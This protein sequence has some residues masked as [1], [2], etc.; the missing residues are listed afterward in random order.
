MA[1]FSF[2]IAALKSTSVDIEE[3]FSAA[4]H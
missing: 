2:S 4:Y 1:A 3:T